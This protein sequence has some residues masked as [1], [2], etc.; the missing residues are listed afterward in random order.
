M[1]GKD[2]LQLILGLPELWLFKSH[3]GYPAFSQNRVTTGQKKGMTIKRGA[4]C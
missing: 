2:K 1:E 4:A 3:I